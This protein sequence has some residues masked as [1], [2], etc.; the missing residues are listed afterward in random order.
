MDKDSLDSYIRGRYIRQ[1]SVEY[2]G[3]EG[4]KR[5][6]GGSVG[7]VGCGALG[8]LV[9]MYLAGSGIGRIGIADFDT[10]DVSNLQRQV[11]YKEAEVGMSKA[12]QLAER[13]K[14]LNS[15]VTVE[16]F[17]EK[18]D[19]NNADSFLGKYDFIIDATDNAESKFMIDRHCRALSV[20]VTTGG[21]SALRGQLTTCM[22]DSNRFESIYTEA[23][24]VRK[25][26]EINGVMGPAPGVLASMQAAEALKYFIMPEKLLV[27]KLLIFDLSENFFR[28]LEY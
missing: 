27:N 10:I 28:I 11:F 22:P 1:I 20:G 14:A 2:V 4:Q 25:N 5:L 24:T 16:S 17:L 6:F 3:E 18:I 13:I 26:G 8:S 9:S 7:I 15:D 21:V 19:E 12:G 23:A